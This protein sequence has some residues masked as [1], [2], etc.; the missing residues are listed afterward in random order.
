[1]RVDI[2]PVLGFDQKIARLGIAF[3]PDRPSG[4]MK[5]DRSVVGE[6]K[7]VAETPFRNDRDPV[8]VFDSPLLGEFPVVVQFVEPTGQAP[9]RLL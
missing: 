1:M 8:A 2:P 6:I 7:I 3:M 5:R 9:S 4:M